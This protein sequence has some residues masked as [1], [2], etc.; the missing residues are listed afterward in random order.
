VQ[1]FKVSA[2]VAT[3]YVINRAVYS[4]LLK[5]AGVHYRTAAVLAFCVGRTGCAETA[6]GLTAEVFA[7]AYAGRRRFRRGPAGPR[8]TLASET[9][10]KSASRRSDGPPDRLR[11]RT[12]WESRA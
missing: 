3:G 12:A 6:A 9:P 11:R 5:G 8:L 2:V 7:A 1:L 4:A 10:A